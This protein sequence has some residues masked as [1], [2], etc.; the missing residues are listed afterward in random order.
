MF[1]FIGTLAVQIMLPPGSTVAGT[2]EKVVVFV[3]FMPM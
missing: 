2:H 1:V 3:E